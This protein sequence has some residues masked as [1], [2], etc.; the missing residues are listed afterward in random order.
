MSATAVQTLSAEDQKEYEFWQSLDSEQARYVSY[1]LH[2][3]DSRLTPRQLSEELK[4]PVARI[5]EFIRDQ[6]LQTY[7]TDKTKQ[8]I[9]DYLASERHRM[10]NVS[11]ALSIE[12]QARIKT[13]Q[14]QRR[15]AEDLFNSGITDPRV[16]KLI[17]AERLEGMTVN[18]LVRLQTHINEK[19]A[20]P[21]EG[22]ESDLSAEYIE[23]MSMRY[24]VYRK[25]GATISASD[26]SPEASSGFEAPI[27]TKGLGGTISQEDINKA[28]SARDIDL[29]S[30]EDEDSE[31]AKNGEEKDD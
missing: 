7:C 15:T 24:S 17:Q 27:P 19:I 11:S 14:T 23:Q 1:I 12:L 5:K 8:I 10:V 22:E 9:K 31:R 28:K 2:E 21:I 16:I 13:T 30:D 4:I 6:R 3:N 20:K 26:F 25:K 29:F 18:E